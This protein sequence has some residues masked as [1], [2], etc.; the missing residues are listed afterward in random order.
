MNIVYRL[1][2]NDGQGGPI[3]YSTPLAE[4]AGLT[5]AAQPLAL[6]SDN[7]FAVRAMDADTG[8]EEANTD[9]RVRIIIDANGQDV[10]ARPNAP[11]ALFARPLVGGTCC[12]TWGYNSRGQA[13]IPAGFY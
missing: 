12:L 11:H 5:F 1:Y 3:D 4:T 8:C 10:S 9:A 2:G 13:G 6:S 7:Q